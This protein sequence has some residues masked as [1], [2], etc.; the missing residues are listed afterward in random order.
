M[1]VFS[2]IILDRNPGWEFLEDGDDIWWCNK[3]LADK[4]GIKE[5]DII[6]IVKANKTV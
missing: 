1:R 4:Y 5:K 6:D 2:E 3:T